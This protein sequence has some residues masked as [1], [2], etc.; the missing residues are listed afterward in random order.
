MFERN[1]VQR[2]S[3]GSVLRSSATS[4]PELLDAELGDQELDPRAAAVL[5]LAEPREHA[6]HG[7]RLGSS[8]CSGVNS[9][10]TFA[11]CGTG[12]RP[13]P[14]TTLKPRTPSTMRAT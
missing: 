7:L 6:R 14:T 13:P 10:S 11:W 3:C 9:E 5:L 1:A 8:S 4:R 12:P 2:S